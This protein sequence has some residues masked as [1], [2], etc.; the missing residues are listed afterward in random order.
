MSQAVEGQIIRIFLELSGRFLL[1]AWP[2]LQLKQIPY[3]PCLVTL[4]NVNCTLA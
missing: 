3:I 2:A 1:A 4:I